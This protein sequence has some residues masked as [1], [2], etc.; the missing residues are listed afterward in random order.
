MDEVELRI[1]RHSGP[2]EE[3][4]PL[5]EEADDSAAAIDSYFELGWVFVAEVAE[6]VVGYLQLIEN[7]AEVLEIK[8]MALVATHRHRGIG[9]ALVDVALDIAREEERRLVRVGTAAADIGNLRFYQRLGFRVRSVERDAF[10][11]RGGYPPDTV[12]DGIPLR[13]RIWLD[14]VP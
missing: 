13:D 7:D 10:T 3:L 12:V 11:V 6:D 5:F 9:G 4:R 8:S 2:R 1:E 14:R